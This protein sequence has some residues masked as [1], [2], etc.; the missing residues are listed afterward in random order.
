MARILDPLPSLLLIVGA[1]LPT[2][3]GC[4]SLVFG[5]VHV[6]QTIT[7]QYSRREFQVIDG[8]TDQ[9]VKKAFVFVEGADASVH[10]GSGFT[11]KNGKITLRVAKYVSGASH[12]EAEGYL[13]SIGHANGNPEKGQ[14]PSPLTII[15]I[16]RQPAPVAGLEIPA[17][18]RGV[19]RVRWPQ[20]YL[21][22]P[23]DYSST[24]W[25]AG[26]R[27]F[28]TKVDPDDPITVAILPPLMGEQHG[29]L[30]CARLDD[31]TPFVS[32]TR[33]RAAD[34]RASI[35]IS[36]RTCAIESHLARTVLPFS[37]WETRRI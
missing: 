14:R 35:S 4:A 2:T 12:A 21:N 24:T 3:Q 10:N 19:F 23:D 33:S 32:R 22:T 34:G 31:G 11:D 7:T 9:P 26:Q 1:I 18:F 29:G 13:H 16:Y 20:R 36:C 6:M 30:W 8:E 5:Y 25:P 28:Y 15:R 17:G 37:N 27:E